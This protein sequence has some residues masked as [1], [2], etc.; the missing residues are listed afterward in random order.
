MEGSGASMYKTI[1]HNPVVVTSIQLANRHF[2]VLIDTM[3]GYPIICQIESQM[4]RVE[5]ELEAGAKKRE[6][7]IGKRA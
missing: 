6:E 4:R 3:N 2:R 7:M 5:R 1:T